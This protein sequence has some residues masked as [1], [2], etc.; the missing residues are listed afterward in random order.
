M[1][2][3]EVPTTRMSIFILSESA[4]GLFGDAFFP[5]NIL[6]TSAATIRNNFN[7][8]VSCFMRAVLLFLHV[9]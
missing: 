5:V 9:H 2:W 1:S 8:N 6:K 3:F 4:G 7:R